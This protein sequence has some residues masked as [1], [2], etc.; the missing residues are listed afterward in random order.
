[1]VC[2][3]EC[4]AWSNFGDVFRAQRLRWLNV[5][6]NNGEGTNTRKMEFGNTP[7]G[8]WMQSVD[9]DDHCG[10]AADEAIERLGSIVRA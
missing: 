7:L 9:H 5:C 6:E 8:G 1:V 10:I 4:Q 2:L 3:L